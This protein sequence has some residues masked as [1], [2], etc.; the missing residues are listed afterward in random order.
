MSFK[1]V[2]TEY[3]RKG[4]IPSNNSGGG[5]DNSKFVYEIGEGKTYTTIQSALEQYEIDRPISEYGVEN[6]VIKLKTIAALFKIYPGHYYGEI[7]INVKNSFLKFIGCGSYTPEH[8]GVVYISGTVSVL[9]DPDGLDSGPKIFY[10]GNV[11]FE[12]IT[13]SSITDDGQPPI[14]NTII[15]P[16]AAGD[17][18][19]SNLKIAFQRCYFQQQNI[20][21]GF[22][23]RHFYNDCT[24]TDTKI[25]SYVSNDSSNSN[26]KQTQLNFSN[27][28]LKRCTIDDTNRTFLK[29][30]NCEIFNS[31]I[32]ISGKC[33][34]INSIMDN[35][36]QTER[37]VF[38]FE[39]QD[40]IEG[41][42]SPK[43]PILNI[44][45]SEIIYEKVSNYF[46]DTS[47]DGYDKP[48]EININNNLITMGQNTPEDAL[49]KLTI[50]PSFLN[51]QG[52][53]SLEC[54]V[55]FINNTI[56]SNSLNLNTNII[57]IVD[58]YNTQTRKLT[59]SNSS[60]IV[61]KGTLGI[62]QFPENLNTSILEFAQISA[63]TNTATNSTP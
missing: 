1:I 43:D 22:L 20:T 28:S 39:F 48:Y 6:D 26:N 33:D 42:N 40:A 53:S 46:I 23:N 52:D 59:V 34:I 54:Q 8:A 16:D 10:N 14:E 36:S 24:L 7:R 38:N 56:L 2:D 12:N 3:F 13:F 9:P 27:T 41:D 61:S 37:P 57:E 60:N 58:T 31:N 21:I 50:N 49:M 51:P 4:V 18:G 30:N 5:E 32:K 17:G 19:E 35:N 25:S 55:T 11:N 62:S 29:I 45:N 63:V 47:Y 15:I 44:Y